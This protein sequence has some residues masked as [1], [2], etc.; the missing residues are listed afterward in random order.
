MFG[1]PTSK[2]NEGLR[3]KTNEI[4]CDMAELTSDLR[5]YNRTKSV[6]GSVVSG[7]DSDLHPLKASSCIN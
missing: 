1:A 5:V 2:S 7:L 4:A 3:I 6:F